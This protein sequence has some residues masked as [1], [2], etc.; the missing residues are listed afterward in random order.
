MKTIVFFKSGRKEE[1]IG[2]LF[3]ILK[4]VLEK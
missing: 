3:E 1:Y 2:E 4:E